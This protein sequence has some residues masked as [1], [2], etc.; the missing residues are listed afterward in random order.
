MKGIFLRWKDECYNAYLLSATYFD[1]EKWMIIEKN[2]LIARSQ[3]FVE[4]HFSGFLHCCII[5]NKKSLVLHYL[6]ILE[7]HELFNFYLEFKKELTQ[8]KLLIQNFRGCIY[9]LDNFRN[10][11]Q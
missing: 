4:R 8:E 7:L 2:K 3:K 11:H 9:N 6:T 5:R 1:N 10:A